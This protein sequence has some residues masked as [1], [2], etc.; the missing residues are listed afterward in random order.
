[1]AYINLGTQNKIQDSYLPDGYVRPIVIPFTGVTNY[2]SRVRV[3]NLNVASY[4]DPDPII[5]MQNIVQAVNDRSIFEV[6]ISF[7]DAAGDVEFYTVLTHLNNNYQD[8]AGSGDW[9]DGSTV[10]RYITKWTIFI[11]T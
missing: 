11:K 3:F 4:I 2:H 7:D 8:V 1:M 9:L 6:E 5:T 10:A